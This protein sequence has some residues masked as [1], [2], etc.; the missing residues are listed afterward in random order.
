VAR[1]VQ[2]E[3]HVDADRR[4]QFAYRARVSSGMLSVLIVTRSA[5]VEE[6]IRG[7][8]PV[9]RADVFGADK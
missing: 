7:P 8:K 5:T 4:V 2:R 9:F 6:S 1:A 3:H